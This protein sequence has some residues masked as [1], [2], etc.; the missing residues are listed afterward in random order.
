MIHAMIDYSDPQGTDLTLFETLGE[1]SKASPAKR[2]F[3]YTT[4]CSS[5][6]KVPQRLIDERT[7]GNP[8]HALFFRMGLEEKLFA[9][10]A[11]GLR[12]VVVRP[13]FI[14]GK[15][16]LTS[17]SGN[18]FAM[19]EAA[20]KSGETITFHGDQDK[21][22]SWV[23]VSDLADAYLKIAEQPFLDGE[24]FCLANEQQPRSLDVMRACLSAAGYSG[25]IAFGPLDESD[26]TSTWADQNEFITSA[27]AR[28]VLGWM[29]LHLDILD[30][31]P[32]IFA[33]FHAAQSV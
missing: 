12:R 27:K 14:Y 30:D 24:V 16:G 26:P 17:M 22:W 23:H 3:I 21:G 9:H 5:Y 6:G 20:A 10:D 32:I 2:L 25:E 33:A 4:G 8:E 18:W 31:A 11:P 15:D 13:G 1:V 28:R 19:G 29:P 7:S